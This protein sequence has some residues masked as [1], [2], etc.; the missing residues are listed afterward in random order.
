MINDQESRS[1]DFRDYRM[2]TASRAA[3]ELE[4][5]V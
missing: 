4:S 5:T 2:N 1:S 3:L